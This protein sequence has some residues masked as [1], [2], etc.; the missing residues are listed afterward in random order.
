MD[1]RTGFPYFS[2]MSHNTLAMLKDYEHSYSTVVTHTNA[3]PHEEFKS[4]YFYRQLFE[5]IFHLNLN[6]TLHINCRSVA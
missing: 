6:L 4:T 1:V 2:L 3:G 5:L